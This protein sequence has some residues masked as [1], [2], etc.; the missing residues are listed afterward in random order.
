M[1][2]SHPFWNSSTK[3]CSCNDNNAEN[4]CKT[5]TLCPPNTF[6]VWNASTETCNCVKSTY[7]KRQDEETVDPS[8]CPTIR[9]MEGYQ[10]KYIKGQAHC[11]CEKIPGTS[12]YP[13]S[14]SDPTLTI[15]SEEPS[16]LLYIKCAKGYIS[17][18]DPKT[19]QCSC[20][21]DPTL[22][23]DWMCIAEQIPVYNA[24]TGKCGCQWI[25]GLEPVNPCADVLCISEM[26]PTVDESTGT[27][28][29]VWIPG[30]EPTPVTSSTQATKTSKAT[31]TPT[32]YDPLNCK[33][34]KIYCPYGDHYSHYNP[35]TK[36][37]ECPP[38]SGTWF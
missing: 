12:S 13:G 23:T 22:C 36:Q 31:A 5:A 29:C 17:T 20:K 35:K 11:I 24:T 26:T 2:G 4:I 14:S 10:P 21:L 34:L 16:C 7:T 30:L 9:C 25:P 32:E 15:H 18:R 3:K 19:N 37:C 38:K 8:T 6:P 28:K 1:T 33:R 27:C